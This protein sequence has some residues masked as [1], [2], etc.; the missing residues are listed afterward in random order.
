MSLLDVIKVVSG[1]IV[2]LAGA[3]GIV[4]FLVKLSANTLADNYKQKVK[5]SFEKELESYK[6]QI[7]ILR[8]TVLKYNDRQFELYLDLWRNLQE[9]KFACIDL[10]NI[11]DKMKLVTFRRALIKCD[12]QIETSSILIDVDHYSELRRIIQ[13]FQDYNFGK[14]RLIESRSLTG[15][16][17]R[18]TAP[19]I[20]EMINHNRLAM[21]RCLE[22]IESIKDE[23]QLTINGKKG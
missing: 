20:Q 14:E 23:I 19:M 1:I 5:H 12:R 4:F 6:S 8:A 10:W 9:L 15:V 3:G 13:S 7:D 11:A 17:G 18:I 21:E 2:S 16:S 22:L